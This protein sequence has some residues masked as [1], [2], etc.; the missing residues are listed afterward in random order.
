MALRINIEKTKYMK[1]TKKDNNNKENL[2]S[3]NL[4][5]SIEQVHHYKYLGSTINDNNSIEE[6]IKGG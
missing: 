1:C 5:M 3:S 6:E 4:N 2:N